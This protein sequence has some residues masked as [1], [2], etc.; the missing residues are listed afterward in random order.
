ML[1]KCY[2]I[3][4]KYMNIHNITPLITLCILFFLLKMSP[5]FYRIIPITAYTC[6]LLIIMLR[7]S[8][9]V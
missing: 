7:S 1:L 9:I 3:N 6:I 2:L 4:N 8:L 5:K